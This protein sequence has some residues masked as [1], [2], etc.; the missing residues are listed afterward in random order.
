MF[1]KD[2]HNGHTIEILDLPELFSLH[3]NDVLGR[4]QVGEE[5]Q[6]PEPYHKSDLLFLSGEELPMC[7]MD[8]EYR[9][10]T[11]QPAQI[12]NRGIW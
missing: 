5:A 3:Q 1:L 7:W 11:L 9:R 6:D 12:S 10:N 2:R 8:P 4:D